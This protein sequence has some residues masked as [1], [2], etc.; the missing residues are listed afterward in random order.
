[1]VAFR[2]AG[3]TA[4]LVVGL[5]LAL[6][7]APLA[8]AAPSAD[9]ASTLVVIDTPRGSTSSTQLYISGWAAD[10]RG[11]GGTGVDKVDV[12]LDGERDAGGT[13]LGRA[14]YGL[15]R[16]DIASH[17]GGTQYTLSGYALVANVT[18]GPHTVYVYA[19]PSDQPA[20]EGWA[21][22]KQ[23]AVLVGTGAGPTAAS[24]APGVPA[25]GPTGAVTVRQAG[26]SGSITYDLPGLGAYYPPG[27]ADMGGPLYSPTYVGWGLYGGVQPFPDV[28]YPSLATW[29]PGNFDF[30]YGYGYD[31]YSLPYL[32]TARYAP[33]YNPY[34]ALLGTYSRFP[35]GNRGPVYCPAYSY[36]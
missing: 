27:P 18:P 5:A 11:S 17:L 33:L 20:E 23:A 31:L 8:R 24:P 7:A 21:A 19:H 12:Y 34:P 2:I 29:V 26:V 25:P 15:S 1:M 6:T 35:W 22:P 9:A 13:Y 4:A 3:L 36:C 10:P 14:T 16:P 32:A 30:S 28:T